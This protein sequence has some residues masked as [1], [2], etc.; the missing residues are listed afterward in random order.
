MVY[1]FIRQSNGHIKVYSEVGHG[2]TVKI[3]LPQ[4]TGSAP[5]LAE[6]SSQACIAGGDEAI[7][8]VEDDALVRR[9]VVTQIQSLGYRTLAAG[10]AS[11]ALT[12]IDNGE[13]IDLLFTDVVMPGSI[14][15]RQL[16]I[17][18]LNRRPSL[19]V[20]YTSGYTKNTMIHHGHLDTEVLLLAKPY[21]KVD[22]AKMIR[23]ALA[24]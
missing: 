3:Y 20:L 16:A 8:V 1:G 13:K 4:A 11:E 15:G 23:A 19:K 7:L 24:A 6:D 9:C 18:A 21:R 5:P 17:E 22:L 10:N 2:T 14:N 12:I